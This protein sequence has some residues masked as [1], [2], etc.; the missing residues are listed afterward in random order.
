VTDLEGLQANPTTAA[1]IRTPT[2]EELAAS[3]RSSLLEP[4][5]VLVGLV[6]GDPFCEILPWSWPRPPDKSARFP[7]TRDEASEML[8]TARATRSGSCEP[9][10]NRRPLMVSPIVGEA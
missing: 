3:G 7:L 1:F 4:L 9:E 6:L 10:S 8:R 5:M 2:D